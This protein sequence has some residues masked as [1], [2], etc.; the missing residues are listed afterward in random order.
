VS[1]PPAPTRGDRR[2]RAANTV[3]LSTALG[4]AVAALGRAEVVRH[5]HGLLLA[6]GHRLPGPLPTAVTVGD[7]VLLRPPLPEVLAH[8][9]RDPRLLEHEARHATQYAWCQGPLLLPLYAA[10]AGWSWLRT[11]DWW[12]RNTF[13]RR[14]GLADGGY[15]ENRTRRRP[16]LRR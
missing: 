14:A 9:A 4:L 6:C 13:E 11:G 8:D 16:E 1:P 15:T 7:V 3:N 12:S 5:R 2:R 10:A